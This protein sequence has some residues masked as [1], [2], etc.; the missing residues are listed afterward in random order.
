MANKQINK[1]KT[2]L[3]RINAEMHRA[4][5]IKAAE[6]GLTLRKLTEGALEF[7]LFSEEAGTSDD[8]ELG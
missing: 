1:T 8:F 2:K 7:A 4:L 3:V 6:R 5:K